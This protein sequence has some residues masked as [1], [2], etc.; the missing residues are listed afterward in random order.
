MTERVGR[1]VKADDR[2]SDVM[3]DIDGADGLRR[4]RDWDV[5]QRLD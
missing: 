5:K 2:S 4:R 1:G 3:S